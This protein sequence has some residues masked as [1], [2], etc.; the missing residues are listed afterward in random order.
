MINSIINLLQPLHQ[1]VHL[2]SESNSILVDIFVYMIIANT[3]KNNN[4]GVK[5]LLK[6]SNHLGNTFYE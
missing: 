4:I 3:Y 1:N 6:K 2:T 5:L